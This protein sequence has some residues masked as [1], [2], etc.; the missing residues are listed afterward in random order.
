MNF[1]GAQLAID[2]KSFCVPERSLVH[3]AE[4]SDIFS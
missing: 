3:G 4:R 2:R 1:N